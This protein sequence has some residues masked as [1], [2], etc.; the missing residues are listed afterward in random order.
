MKKSNYEERE[1]EFL[2]ELTEL[3]HKHKIFIGGCGCCGSPYLT[4]FIDNNDLT[5]RIDDASASFGFRFEQVPADLIE[6]S[7]ESQL[8]FEK[9][10]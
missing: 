4:D 8:E 7:Y 1:K 3:S 2:K 5:A 9:L 10:K 6:Y